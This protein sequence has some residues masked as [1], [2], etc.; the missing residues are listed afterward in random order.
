MDK[1]TSLGEFYLLDI[2]DFAFM[3]LRSF[4]SIG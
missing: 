3:I 1:K 2:V 4:P